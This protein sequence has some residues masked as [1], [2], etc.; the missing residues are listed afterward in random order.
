MSTTP[1]QAPAA[2]APS[3]GQNTD[4]L[5][6]I[7]TI[8][9]ALA[10]FDRNVQLRI[11]KWTKEK[12]G[13]VEPETQP[14]PAISQTHTT[15]PAAHPP[16]AEHEHG[17]SN[18]N[19][20]D[21][22]AEKNP[23]SNNEFAAA[24]AYFYRFEAPVSARQETI[25]ADTLLE[26]CRL[27]GRQRLEKPNATLTHAHDMG[28]LDRGERGSYSISTVGEN[29]VA[30]TLPSSIAKA[31]APRKKSVSRKKTPARRTK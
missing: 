24:V 6:A 19:I 2:T 21:F 5:D 22:I 27:C 7:R 17:K 20:K 30:M 3:T 14:P 8:S 10:P 15:P 11:L 31:A 13:L 23:S 12:L 25:N 9:T 29:L 16:V 28:Y 18:K 26:A 4:D 1:H